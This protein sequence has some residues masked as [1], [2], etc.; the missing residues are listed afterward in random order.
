M[1]C[2]HVDNRKV[3]EGR[4]EKTEIRD[5]LF[6]LPNLVGCVHRSRCGQQEGRGGEGR[7]GEGEGRGGGDRL[8]VTLLNCRKSMFRDLANRE[9]G[10][11]SLLESVYGE[12]VG[13]NKRSAPDD[14]SKETA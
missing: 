13:R 10:F 8:T 12:R 2:G 11:E 3:G 14:V 4:G 9:V 6:K 1:V 5:D 7:G